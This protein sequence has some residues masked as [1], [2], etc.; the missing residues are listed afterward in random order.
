MPD[1][2]IS[3]DAV[4]SLIYRCLDFKHS[5]KFLNIERVKKSA[6]KNNPVSQVETPFVLDT[7][8]EEFSNL[9]NCPDEEI[10]I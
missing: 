4:E 2:D 10:K 9:W 1:S 5:L 3:D 7:H 6:K 8:I